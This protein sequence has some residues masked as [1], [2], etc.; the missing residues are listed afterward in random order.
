ML[1]RTTT[2]LDAELVPAPGPVEVTI[3]QR[4]ER[5]A[6]SMASPVAADRLAL[7][8]V[9]LTIGKGDVP[10]YNDEKAT[11]LKEV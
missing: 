6:V 9:S 3:G 10:I 7:G 2:T 1:P 5:F 11:Y 4:T 8:D